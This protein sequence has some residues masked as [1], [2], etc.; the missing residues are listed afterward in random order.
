MEQ[1][2]SKPYRANMRYHVLAVDYDGT[3]AHDG[4]VDAPTLD[5]LRRLAETGRKLVLVT[6]RQLDDLLEVFPDSS[7][8][9]RIVA[10]NGAV[11]HRPDTKETRD[12]A[13]PVPAALADILRGAGVAPLASG[14]VIV[15]TWQP[16][17]TTVLEAIRTLGLELQVIFNKGAVMVLPSGVNK[18]SGLLA[19]LDD[20]K[21]SA[22]NCVGIGDAENDH[23]FLGVCECAVAVAN[24]LP[25][26]KETADWVTAGD[27]GAGV[28]EIVE[29]LVRADLADLEPRLDRH[30]I[31]LGATVAGDPVRLSPYGASVLIAG[32]SG[33]GKSTLS[34]AL[35]EHLMERGYQVC[36][37]DPEGDYS[38]LPDAIV[39]G[40]QERGPSPEEI[41]DV[42]EAPARHVVVS[43]LGVP[44]NE[45]PAFFDALL[46]R[47][48]EQRARVGRPHWLVIDEA[49]HLLPPTWNPATLTLPRA[50]TEVVLVTVHPEHVAPAVLESVSM[51]VGVGGSGADAIRGFCAATGRPAPAGAP[52]PLGPGEA[53]A[54]SPR[55]DAAPLVFR[56]LPPR[57]ERRRHVR[58]YAE[59][60]LGPDRSFYFRGRDDRLNLRAQ[61]LGL[62]VQIADGVDDETW[63]HHL[64]R[65]DYSRWF[66]D[67]I[68]NED[69]A[70]EAAAIE[71]KADAPASDSRARIRAAI[72]R[73]YTLPA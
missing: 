29:G 39:L 63:L 21:I 50:L 56:G 14:R 2:R 70:R 68:K 58:K 34:T 64:R 19:A 10:E 37:I 5:A 57:A 42:M 66:R 48:Q 41:L 61:N 8:F 49:H 32:P 20:L 11:L 38:S 73:R 36:V 22:H 9:T 65:G 71:A 44:L 59:G 69:L 54:W 40:D 28:I 43:L 3:L 13:E 46:P 1:L 23:A 52:A 25:M 7:L 6:G 60:E 33:S 16:W 55:G 47:L 67:A 51:V 17:D 35:M 18:A 27:H 26:L 31:S 53:L 30:A 72:G 15:S 4:E 62:F 45:R 24:A 12:L